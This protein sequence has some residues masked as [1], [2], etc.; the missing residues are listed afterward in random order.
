MIEEAMAY[1]KKLVQDAQNPSHVKVGR[2]QY[3]TYQGDLRPLPDPQ[4]NT[5]DVNTL[6]G[7]A[8]LVNSDLRRAGTILHVVNPFL[9]S[10]CTEQCDEWGRRQ[11]DVLCKLPSLGKF[12]FGE[13]M[14]QE[15]FIIG[16]QS[17]FLQDM[18]DM[19][20]LYNLAGN[21]TAEQVQSATDDGITQRAAARTGMVLASTVT[22]KARVELRPWRTFRE[23][24]QPSSVFLLRLKNQDKNPPLLSLH[25]SDGELWQNEAI[26][27]ISFWLK[28]HT[29]GIKIVA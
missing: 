3:F 19:A 13:W 28:S 7:L 9:V 18:P 5:I 8:E 4:D 24:A 20:G 26:R 21:L 16:L 17:F 15:R 22:V 1:V 12:P 11:V 14:D 2:R 29:A 10:V 23:I 6:T 27:E 25:I